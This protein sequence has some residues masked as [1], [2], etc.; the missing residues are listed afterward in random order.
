VAISSRISARYGSIQVRFRVG[1][2][3][4]PALAAPA[5]ARTVTN[6]LARGAAPTDVI[7]AEALPCACLKSGLF[8]PYLW[9]GR[10]SSDLKRQV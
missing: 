1:C 7:G 8:G 6:D 2:E 5:G 3:A 4:A 10:F 9:Y